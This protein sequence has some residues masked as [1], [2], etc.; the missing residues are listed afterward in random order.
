MAD[1]PAGDEDDGESYNRLLV[2]PDD[3]SNYT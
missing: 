1:A 3:R 2:L